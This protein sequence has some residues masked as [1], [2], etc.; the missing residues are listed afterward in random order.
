MAEKQAIKP[1]ERAGGFTKEVGSTLFQVNVR[2]DDAGKE[3]LEEKILRM[4]KNDLTGGA[5]CGN[6]KMPQADLLPERG[7]V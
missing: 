3:S 5:R 7:S 2:F 6:I 4:L 1:I